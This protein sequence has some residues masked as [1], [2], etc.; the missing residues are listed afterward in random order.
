MPWITSTE[1]AVNHTYSGSGFNFGYLWTIALAINATNPF[2]ERLYHPG[3]NHTRV[4][5]TY[6]ACLEH[7]GA[8]SVRYS[9]RDV[10]DRV[11]LWRIPLIALV[12]TTTLP[13]LVSVD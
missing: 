12:A 11:L 8:D 1:G 4:C 9:R 3:D 2:D 7:V 10:Y 5:S 6:E 13:A